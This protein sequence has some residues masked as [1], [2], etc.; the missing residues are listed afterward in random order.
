MSTGSFC[1]T[2]A[3]LVVHDYDC[4]LQIKLFLV[5]TIKQ[6]NVFVM[7]CIFPLV[8]SIVLFLQLVYFLRYQRSLVVVNGFKLKF[9][10]RFLFRAYFNASDFHNVEWKNIKDARKSGVKFVPHV[11]HEITL[12]SAFNEL[13]HFRYDAASVI[14][15]VNLEEKMSSMLEIFISLE[16][17]NMLRIRLVWL[18]HPLLVFF[19]FIRCCPNDLFWWFLNGAKTN[20]EK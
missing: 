12:F 16:S 6:W 1:L 11:L 9:N 17:G 7:K 5:A 19:R 2:W 8:L 18:H 14:S 10:D 20:C 13:Y 15:V 3:M 4:V